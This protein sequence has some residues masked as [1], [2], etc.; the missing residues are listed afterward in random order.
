MGHFGQ[1]ERGSWEGG[2]QRRL[3]GKPPRRQEPPRPWG[4]VT[5]PRSARAGTARTDDTSTANT[6]DKADDSVITSSRAVVAGRV[7]HGQV[8]ATRD[9]RARVG[10]L[11]KMYAH[12]IALGVR[13]GSA[14]HAV[15]ALSEFMETDPG[16]RGAR[17]STPIP[18]TGSGIAGTFLACGGRIRIHH[19]L[20]RYPV[21]KIHHTAPRHRARNPSV[22]IRL[23]LTLTSAIS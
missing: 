1:L 6:R 8:L 3:S 7:L 23:A 19:A 21:L 13:A 14:D 22:A 16:G 12:D 2:A 10:R 20:S 17:R 15:Q 4:S 9:I 5:A 18:P 11:E